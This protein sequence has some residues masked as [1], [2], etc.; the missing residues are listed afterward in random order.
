MGEIM[1]TFFMI[2]IMLGIIFGVCIVQ[3]IYDV[4]KLTR[5]KKRKEFLGK[6]TE[7]DYRLCQEFYDKMF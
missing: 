4:I 1:A 5:E 6:L 2:G 7:N 3:I